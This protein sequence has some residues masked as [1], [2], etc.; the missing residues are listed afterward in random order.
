MSDLAAIATSILLVAVVRLSHRIFPV[1]RTQWTRTVIV[2]ILGG[3]P[4]IIWFWIF[5]RSFLP[6]RDFGQYLATLLWVNCPPLGVFLGLILG[7]ETAA[8]KKVATIVS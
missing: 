1:I 7:I 5:A 6:G 3:V 8:R 4:A 2:F